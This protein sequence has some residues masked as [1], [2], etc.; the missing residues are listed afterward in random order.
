MCVSLCLPIFGRAF[1]AAK[2][3]AIAGL[4]GPAQY[5]FDI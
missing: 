4:N 1:A 5:D 2:P 3:A